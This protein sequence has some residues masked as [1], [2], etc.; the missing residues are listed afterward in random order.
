MI[1]TVVRSREDYKRR[2][3]T[4]WPALLFD[5]RAETET[6]LPQ[7]GTGTPARMK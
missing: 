6:P 7:V 5:E 2:T 1:Y 3:A 4:R